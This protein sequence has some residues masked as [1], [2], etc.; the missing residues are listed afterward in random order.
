MKKIH[1]I[2]SLLATL[3]VLP[4]YADGFYSSLKIQDSRQ[5]LSEALLTSPRVDNRIASPEVNKRTAGSFAF[6]Y[7]FDDYLRMEAEYTT[8]TN[9]D[10]K[11][12]WSPFNANVNTMQVSSERLMLNGY[13]SYPLSPTLSLYGMA[14]V[15]TALITSEGYQ[16][17]PDRRFADNR[18][19][20]AAYSLGVGADFKLSEKVTL[21]T[22][23][24]QVN[25][26]KITT[27]YNTFANRINARDE[28][29][30]GRLKEQNIFLE[31]RLSL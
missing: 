2:A 11:S 18:Q 24:R 5:T 20:K 4:A 7:V 13:A 21:G 29:L 3:T 31:M 12:Y 1:S 19:Y 14:G 23:Y 30:K 27:G 25:M 10:Y 22:G 16:S 26:G 17:T 6:G 8:R 9:G 28:Q 15:G